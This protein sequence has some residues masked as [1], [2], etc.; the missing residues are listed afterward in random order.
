MDDSNTNQLDRILTQVNHLVEY[1]GKDKESLL[2]QI[3]FLKRE[4]KEGVH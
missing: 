2:R 3:R 4:N 1:Q